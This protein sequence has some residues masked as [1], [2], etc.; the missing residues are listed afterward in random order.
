VRALVFELRTDTL[1]FRFKRFDPLLELSNR[2]PFQYF[3]DNH[4][5]TSR[6]RLLRIIPIPLIVFNQDPTLPRQ[7]LHGGNRTFQR[8]IFK[9]LTNDLRR[10]LLA[11]LD[12]QTGRHEH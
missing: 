3:A 8:R 2:V 4:L 10:Q 11:L 9:E 5:L 1:Y 7:S 6:W 12:V